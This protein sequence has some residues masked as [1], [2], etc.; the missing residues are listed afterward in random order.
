MPGAVGVPQTRYARS[1]DIHI[2]YQVV[3]GGPLDLVWIPSLAHHVEP[4]WENPVVERFLTRLAKLG[5]LIVFDKRGTGMPDRLR[6]NLDVDVCGVLPSIR[7]PTLILH[8]KDD[9]VDESLRSARYDRGS[10]ELRGIPGEW[11]LFAVEQEAA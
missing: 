10:S 1:G 6:M 11:R 5:R 4:N 9:V 8:R 3:G 2:A 7:V